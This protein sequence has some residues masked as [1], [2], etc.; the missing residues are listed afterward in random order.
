MPSVQVTSNEVTWHCGTVSALADRQ[1]AW[2]SPRRAYDRAARP[3]DRDV[4]AQHPQPPVARAAPAPGGPRAVGYYGPDHVA[5]LRLVQEMQAEGF[6]LGAIRGSRRSSGAADRLLGFKRDGHRRRSR[7]NRRRSSTVA[8]WPSASVPR[9][10]AAR[11]GRAPGLLVPVGDGRYEAPSPALL[12]A[13]EEVLS[14]GIPCPRRSRCIEQVKRNCEA[15]L[16]CVRKAVP[17]GAMDALD[18]T[19]SRSSGGTRS[20]SRS[21][22]CARCASEALLAMFKQTMAAEVE[23]AFGKA[24]A[25][26]VKRGR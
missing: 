17:G 19:A 26:Q 23:D 1:E 3:G 20:T 24:L 15:D 12:R 14:R 16:A 25:R 18:A 21:S 10:Q 13:A 4:G 9:P 8:S 7:P 5:R 11:A 22:A 2:L 6:N